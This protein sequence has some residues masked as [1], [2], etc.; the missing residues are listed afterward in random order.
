M[1]TKER[2]RETK[3][4]ILSLLLDAYRRRERVGLVVFQG[5][6]AVTALPFT[7]SIEMA[8]RYLRDLPTGG[9]TPLPH[10]LAKAMELITRERAKHPKDAFL[11]VLITDGKANVSLT[12]KPAM[13][14]VKEGH[15]DRHPGH[16]YP[17]PQYRTLRPLP[18][19][20]RPAGNQPIN[21]RGPL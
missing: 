10:G 3:A 11:L 9:K 7:H 4:A 6:K 1:G 12:G 19:S 2:M 5:N 21:G 13:T 14:E 8:Q 17:G 16:Q 18:G 15:P 20:G